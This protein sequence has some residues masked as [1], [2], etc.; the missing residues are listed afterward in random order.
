M[1][2]ELPSDVKFND[3]TSN[4]MK[5]YIEEMEGDVDEDLDSLIEQLLPQKK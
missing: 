4:D 1:S 3:M 5:K 2:E